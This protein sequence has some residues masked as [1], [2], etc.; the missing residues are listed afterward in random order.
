MAKERENAGP[1]DLTDVVFERLTVL[2]YSG[3]TKTYTSSRKKD[4]RWLCRC[5]CGNEVEVLGDS[6]R[7]GNTMSCGCLQKENTSKSRRIDLTG[8]VVDKLTVLE[9]SHAH[10][11]QYFWKCKCECGKEKA[12][13]GSTLRLRKTKSCGCRQ[14]RFIHG[15]WGKTGLQTCLSF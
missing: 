3:F 7:S 12:I 13:N 8:L 11:G 10:N 15:M 14:G 2:S 9:F 5:V 4:H 1:D 6:L